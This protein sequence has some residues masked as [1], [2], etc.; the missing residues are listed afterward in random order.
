MTTDQTEALLTFDHV[1]LVQ[2]GERLFDDMDFQIARGERLAIIGDSGSGKSVILRLAI[3]LMPP[4]SGSVYL[5]GSDLADMDADACRIKRA[6]CGLAMQGG[7]LL[8]NLSVEDNL[9]LGLGT[10]PATRSRLRRRIDRALL[11][12]GLEH[13]AERSANALSSGE[14][15]RVELARAFLR[16]PELVIL[17]EPFGGHGVASSALEAQVTRQIGPRGRAL[18][19]LTQDVMLA[20]RQC[21]RILYLDRGRLVQQSEN[22]R[23]PAEP[24]T[25]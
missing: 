23:I 13:A 3:G 25:S 12:Y 20:K 11:E 8:G 1:A 16:D 21:D 24:L 14:R 7:S 2:G 18:L 4:T 10:S 6:R 22:V 5:F 19:L 15:L 17:D 9:L